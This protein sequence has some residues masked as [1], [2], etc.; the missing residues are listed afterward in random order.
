[1]TQDSQIYTVS[2]VPGIEAPAAPP[3]VA[4]QVEVLFQL[5][6]ATAYLCPANAKAGSTISAI[7][8]PANRANAVK[9]PVI[10]EAGK[11]R[12]GERILITSVVRVS[13][14]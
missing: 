13:E 14:L 10:R 3:E 12:W 5:A 9:P 6:L 2:L 11:Y 4:D 7:A 1:M 8:I